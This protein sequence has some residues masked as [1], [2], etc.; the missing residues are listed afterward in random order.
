MV[1]NNLGNQSTTGSYTGI[2]GNPAFA[3]QQTF[4]NPFLMPQPGTD[5]TGVTQMMASMGLNQ[6]FATNLGSFQMP[7]FNPFLFPG[8]NLAISGASSNMNPFGSLPTFGRG[9]P[10]NS[11]NI[12]ILPCLLPLVQNLSAGRGNGRGVGNNQ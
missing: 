1:N 4:M 7:A 11:G 6:G 12:G 9:Q 5:M 3:Q 10:M 8:N 2:M